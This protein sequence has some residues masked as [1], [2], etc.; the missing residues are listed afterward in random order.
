MILDIPVSRDNI[1]DV[2]WKLLQDYLGKY[3]EPNMSTLHY[4]VCQ[5]I[6]RL[7]IYIPFW[8][9]SSYKVC[10]HFLLLFIYFGLFYLF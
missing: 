2:V 9:I 10:T 8:L 5:Q 3:E 7:N 4:V 1:S 6:I